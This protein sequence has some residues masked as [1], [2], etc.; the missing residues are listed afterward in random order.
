MAL[1]NYL[2]KAY[3]HINRQCIIEV[4][5]KVGFG[6]K[7]CNLISACLFYIPVSIIINGQASQKFSTSCGIRQGDPLSPYL[8]LFG[9]LL[10][11]KEIANKFLYGRISSL[12]SL[13]DADISILTYVDDIL[14]F[15]KASKTNY[16]EI[17]ELLEKF[18]NWT[19][20][21]PNLSKSSI[22]FSP[23]THHSIK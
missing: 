22:M 5:K 6:T 12:G 1:K 11:E 16:L 23:C 7:W 10:L 21:R 17:L 15:F 9:M 18:K 4:M 20:L 19:G 2:S 8:F 3:D 13:F 14:L